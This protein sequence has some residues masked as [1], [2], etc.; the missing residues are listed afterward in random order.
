VVPRPEDL[1]L[2]GL[3]V[4]G[5]ALAAALRVDVDEWRRELPSIH[6]D[7]SKYGARLPDAVREELDAL[8]ERLAR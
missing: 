5:D 7:F 1:Q 4:P 2:D 6:D 3:D 8:E